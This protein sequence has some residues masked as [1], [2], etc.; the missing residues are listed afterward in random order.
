MADET[1]PEPIHPLHD[2][3]LRPRRVVRELADAPITRVDYL[4]GAVQGI[5][6][7][8]SLSRAQSAGANTDIAGILGRAL[9]AGPIAG[10][11]GLYL[12]TAVYVRLGRRAGG[13]ATRT[14]I[15]HVLAYSGAP[16]L[17]SLAIW[18][19]TAALAGAP[20]FESTPPPGLEPFVALLVRTGF[21][22]H[23]LLVCWSLLLQVMGFSE[24]ERLPTR[25]AFAIWLFGQ[26]LVMLAILL[27][28]ILVI[29]LGAS[30][31][32]A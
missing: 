13:V 18:L 29:G 10:I 27:L 15:F 23:V 22:V 11:I 9:I 1:P 5:V 2:V 20:T 24:A 17:A 14:Q 32:T 3:W 6:S 26:A 28:W 31:P 30:P 16:M 7:W 19:L 12:M 8:L 4:L 25:R 21:L